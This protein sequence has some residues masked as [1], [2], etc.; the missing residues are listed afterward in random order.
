MSSPCW[1]QKFGEHDWKGLHP[2]CYCRSVILDWTNQQCVEFKSKLKTCSLGFTRPLGCNL[3]KNN[4]HITTLFILTRS[5]YKIYSKLWITINLEVSIWLPKIILHAQ[6]VAIP[7]QCT[8]Y[9]LARVLI[10]LR[11]RNRRHN[12]HKLLKTGKASDKSVES[13]QT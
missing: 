13:Q 10:L 8:E 11:S 6:D 4:I 5:N 1:P 7:T 3:I 12:S 2:E 9:K